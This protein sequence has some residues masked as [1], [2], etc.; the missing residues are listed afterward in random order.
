MAFTQV[1]IEADNL[2]LSDGTLIDG[3]LTFTPTATM[4][5]GTVTSVS[6]SVT[7]GVSAGSM[8]ALTLA[9]TN[10][11]DTTPTGVMY[12]VEQRIH[13]QSGVRTYY[14]AVPYDGGPL[15]LNTA[16]IVETVPGAITIPVAG[17][18]GPQGEQGEQGEPGAAGEG[19]PPAVAA[20]NLGSTAVAAADSIRAVGQSRIE[21]EDATQ[22]VETWTDTTAWA[23]AAAIA[24][25]G[26]GR[27][28]NVGNFGANRS[29]PV[30]ADQ[31]LRVTAAINFVGADPSTG[32]VMLGVSNDTAGATMTAAGIRGIGFETSTRSAVYWNGS[33]FTYATPTI[34]APDGA[35]YA[36][37]TA[38]DDVIG[39]TVA[40]PDRVVEWHA[41]MPRSGFN[42]NN[43]SLYS[44][45]SR[46]ITGSTHG[47]ITAKA[48]HTTVR[49]PAGVD[50][51][52]P[53]VSWGDTGG[54][55]ASKAR[56]ILPAGFDP[57][58]PTSL[59]IVFHGAGGDAS[60][61]AF[62]EYTLLEAGYIVAMSDGSAPIHTGNQ[63]AVD[64]YARL[65]RYVRD[66]LPIGPVVL[67]AESMGGLASLNL[68]TQQAIPRP[69][70][71]LGYFP[72][73]NLRALYDLTPDNATNIR[74]AYGIAPDGSDYNTLTAGHDPNLRSADDF[75][76]IPMLVFHSPEDTVVPK[77]TNVDLL[78]S[79]IGSLA[80]EA[81][82]I[83]T[84]GDHGDELA[85]LSTENLAA[86]MAFLAR[87]T[88]G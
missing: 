5:N 23:D 33:A 61:H 79:R 55:A 54:P 26:D 64:E 17:P 22:F 28:Y 43:V 30:T 68:I 76:G 60:S 72:A 37:V 41:E 29:F 10:D 73:T 35:Y 83:V 53:T 84:S 4:R 74:A 21:Y 71:W 14:L 48:A 1:T 24:A 6:G 18:Q 16:T 15:D 67:V 56:I 25:T 44:S 9:A 58:L 66:R 65:Y 75:A 20:R 45:D 31:S 62:I 63:A 40:S 36:T 11:P 39:F 27:A 81:T 12:R 59:A 57:R 51:V 34:T 88:Q 19:V 38:D 49:P 3:S 50:T 78:M 2:R 8:G 32:W 46:G 85:E 13:R 80:A 70:A 52:W 86:A 7:A 82:T 87:W 77:A 69:A 47:P 42:I